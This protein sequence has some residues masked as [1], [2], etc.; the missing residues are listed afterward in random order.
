MVSVLGAF[1]YDIEFIGTKQQVNCN[2]LSRLPR[3]KQPADKPDE[4]EMFHAFVIETLP[5]SEQELRLQTRRDPVLSRVLELVEGGLQ[6]AAKSTPTSSLM[7][8]IA[9]KSQS[10]I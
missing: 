9:A 1:M 6:T 5:V 2:G 10:T 7:P 8:N 3:P 4:V